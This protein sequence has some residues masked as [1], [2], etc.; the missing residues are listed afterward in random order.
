MGKGNPRLQFP[1]CV[2][3]KRSK[4]GP[5]ARLLAFEKLQIW[6]F[7]LLG[8]GSAQLL[9]QKPERIAETKIEK[10][11]QA[12][13]SYH[14][15]GRELSKEMPD[16]LGL[17]FAQHV[18]EEGKY[19]T[20]PDFEILAPLKKS[21]AS[22]L[23]TLASKVVSQTAEIL[24][25]RLAFLE[26]NLRELPP[27]DFFAVDSLTLE[28]I[29]FEPYYARDTAELL[30][31]WVRGIKYQALIL[32]S[33]DST[34]QSTEPAQI[35]AELNDLA[36][37][38]IEISQCKMAMLRATEGGLESHALNA[39]MR[40]LA[41]CF[42]PNTQYF[43]EEDQQSFATSLSSSLFSTGLILGEDNP[44]EVVITYIIPESHAWELKT[45]EEGDEVLN[46]RYKQLDAHPAC[47]S[48]PVLEE[49]FH[50]T[51]IDSLE[52]L[53]RS[54]KSGKITPYTLKKR[55]LQNV[56]NEV[57]YMLLRSG[58][59][60]YGYILF[61]SFYSGYSEYE[62]QS[63][64]DLAKILL[65]MRLR[66]VDGIMLDLRGNGGGSIQ[67]AIRLAGFFVDSGPLFFSSS[68]FDTKPIL[69]RDWNKGKLYD[70]KL[71]ILTN[72]FTASASEMLILALQNYQNLVTVGSKTYGKATG[73]EVL[74]MHLP[75]KEEPF[76][77]LKVTTLKVYG[78]GGDSYQADGIVPTIVVPDQ[79]PQ[80][81]F[82]ESANKYALRFTKIPTA[83]TTWTEYKPIPTER[84]RTSYQQRLDS[85]ATLH[86]IAHYRDSLEQ[87]LRQPL[88]VSLH[89]EAFRTQTWHNKTPPIEQKNPVFATEDILRKERQSKSYQE[90]KKLISKDPTLN[91]AFLIMQDWQASDLE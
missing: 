46:V 27:I 39:M 23:P 9:A 61:P 75:G 84:L 89:Y 82:S 18:D 71:M 35:N 41:A 37:Q 63:S 55:H 4:W 21:S 24:D 8:M 45:I 5:S 70:G 38:V 74:P 11:V 64:E 69:N 29:H 10:V 88:K 62:S 79:I 91:E 67:E 2:L 30:A 86:Q 26:G 20:L 43:S 60:V 52:V 15:D 57:S 7:L 56:S 80:Q 33:V 22:N 73:Q 85:N 78:L 36:Q 54:R 32:Y 51:E 76:G 50:S 49:A 59:A 6:L 31:S 3:S 87:L 17:L 77:Y 83:T 58:E 14:I 28:P 68:S 81:I 44:G 12:L 65:V 72:G 48:W 90:V 40:A 42:D 16:R 13:T 66:K 25:Q 34:R 53:I 47:I 19:L 1:F